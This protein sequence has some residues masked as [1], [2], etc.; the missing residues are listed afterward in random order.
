MNDQELAEIRG[1][2]ERAT[3]GPWFWPYANTLAEDNGD[4]EGF[5]RLVVGLATSITDADAKFIAHARQDLPALLEE[6]ER[7]R[8]EVQ[9]HDP[10]TLEEVRSIAG[11]VTGLEAEN[12]RL[13]AVVNK[14]RRLHDLKHYAD[15]PGVSAAMEEYRQAL[16]ALDEEEK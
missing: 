14:G 11:R 5:G 8:G 4:P 3:P 2:V 1:R 6:I 7:L 12:A 15:V 13:R 9:L 16:S 10:D